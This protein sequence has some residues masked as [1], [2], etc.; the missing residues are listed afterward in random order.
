MLIKL[1][2]KFNIFNKSKTLIKVKVKVKVIAI[3]VTI[4][5]K[6]SIIAKK[7]IA[8]YTIKKSKRST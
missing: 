5:I 3:I 1:Q 8:T 4:I 6:K 7:A 2:L